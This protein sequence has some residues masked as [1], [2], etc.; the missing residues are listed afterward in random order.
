MKDTEYTYAVAYIKTLEN[1][2]LTLK[3]VENL[4]NAPDIKSA[5]KILSDRGYDCDENKIVD[6]D[7]VLKKEIERIWN[8]TRKCTPDGAPLDIL[9]YRNDFHNLKT[10]LKAFITDS[11][12]QH[13]ILTPYL[14]EPQ[15]IYNAFINRDF[16]VLPKH[17]CDAARNSYDI[18]C[19]TSDGQAAEIYL[20]KALA[21]QTMKA[22]EDVG[23][24]IIIKWAKLNIIIAKN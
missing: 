2:M 21:E 3:D 23:I 9:L 11:K 20:D 12:W 13:L 14:T 16:Q 5:L 6:I 8:D 4:L 17:I 1:K 19:E 22:A 15:I 18:I 7:T 10:I 24:E